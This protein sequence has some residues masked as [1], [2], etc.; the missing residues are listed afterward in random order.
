MSGN[1]LGAAVGTVHLHLW[2]GALHVILQSRV[3]TE[4]SAGGHISAHRQ[5][6]GSEPTVNT[7]ITV[8]NLDKLINGHNRSVNQ[9]NPGL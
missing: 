5:L 6:S 2:T 4:T 7:E 1:L 8:N 3:T 9:K